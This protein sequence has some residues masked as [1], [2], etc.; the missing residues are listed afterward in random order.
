[1]SKWK[2]YKIGDI[3]EVIG[4]GTPSTKINEYWGGEIPWL[5]PRDLTNHKSVQISKGERSITKLGLDKSSARLLPKGTVLLTSR[6]PIGYVAIAT[7]PISTNQGFK[8]LIPKEGISLGLF[9]YYWLKDNKE[10]L[11][12]NG[13][14]TTFS[15]ISGTVVK[16]L[17]ISLPP[18]PE[19]KAIAEV[20]SSLDDKIDLLHRQNE[21]LEKMA[22]TLFKK[23]FV[24][25][26]DD[27]W[28]EAEISKIAIFKNGKSKPKSDGEIP[29]YGGNGILG[30][31]NEFNAIGESI[32][33]G[34]VGAYC[35]SLYFENRAIW[36]SDNAILL[37]G[38]E[39]EFIYF[40]FYFLK[41]QNLNDLA[42][43]SSH[44]L[45]T[46]TLLNKIQI[47][48]PP[49]KV[50]NTFNVQVETWMRKK[51]YNYKQIHNLEKLR[52]TLLPKLISGEV[53]VEGV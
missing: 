17:D 41:N 11:E 42:E 5:T 15:E 25:D 8:N 40:L 19:Q 6:A 29:I 31:T 4:G 38:K 45:L 37:K 2:E 18:L 14:G 7:N 13:S 33:I 27:G 44:P 24:E 21:T 3:S 1:M 49:I 16:L 20:L 28:E 22:E 39:E 48:I 9:L 46:Q 50:I 51:E 52:D 53:R 10:Y 43:G 32:I 30:F 47:L 26:A 23:W 34:R 12:A 36:I 35:G